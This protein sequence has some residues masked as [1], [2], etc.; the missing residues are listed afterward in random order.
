MRDFQKID[1]GLADAESERIH[2][3]ALLVDGYLDANGYIDKLLSDRYF[4]VIGPK[5]SG[6]SAIGSK[7]SLL[8]ETRDDLYVRQYTL[9]DFPYNKF[10]QLLPSKE[11]TETRYPMNWQFILYATFLNSISHDTSAC[12]SFMK[13]DDGINIFKKMGLLEDVDLAQLVTRATKK[14]FELMI[15]KILSVKVLPNPQKKAAMETV[16]NGM[17]RLCKSV[18][19]PNQHLIIIDGL[20]D[21]LTGRD[22]QY[23]SLSALFISTDRINKELKEHNVNA[24]VILLCRRDLLDKLKDPNLNKIITDYGI[25]LDWYQDV[26]NINATNLVQLINHRA[27]VTLKRDVDVFSEFFPENF[28]NTE[29]HSGNFNLKKL[30][31]RT[32]HTPRDTLQLMKHIQSYVS[33]EKVTVDNIKNGLRKYSIEYFRREIADELVGFITD[34]EQDCIFELLSSYGKSNFTLTEIREIVDSNERFK[35]LDLVKIFTS[36]YNCNVVGN[37]NERTNFMNWKYRN[38]YSSFSPDQLILVHGGLLKALNLHYVST[39]KHSPSPYY[40]DEYM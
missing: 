3:P 16:Y 18:S 35:N 22:R 24:K 1:F 14:E 33:G 7:I 12:S 28:T 13:L 15:P 9:R 31:Y 20:D 40:Y 26:Q 23:L 34:H 19:T 8:S 2:S 4:L 27:K 21:V 6:K 37:Y 30:L 17:K 39:K 11:A 5:G 38:H 29:S 10:D 32:R 25:Y 36:L